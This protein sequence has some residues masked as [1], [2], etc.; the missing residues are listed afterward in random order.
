MRISYY[1]METVCTEFFTEVTDKELEELQA[2]SNEDAR[3][4]LTQQ[5]AVDIRT[6]DWTDTEEPHAWEEEG[7][8]YY[9]IEEN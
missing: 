6:V 1:A 9:E 2:M 8:S 7:G 5:E 4:F 3:F